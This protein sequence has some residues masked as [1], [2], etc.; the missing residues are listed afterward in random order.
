MY[1]NKHIHN[2]KHVLCINTNTASKMT[3]SAVYRFIC[4]IFCVNLNK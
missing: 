2:N 4:F 3:P 1:H